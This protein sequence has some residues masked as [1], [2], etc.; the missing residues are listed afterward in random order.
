MKHLIFGRQGE[1]LAFEYL[2]KH[3]V[4]IITKNYKNKLG[5]IDL[6]GKDK[7]QIV[8]FEVKRSKNKRFG[9][10]E[11]RVNYQ[12]I[13]KIIKVGQEFLVRNNLI[14]QSWRIDVISIQNMK[15]KWI[16]NVTN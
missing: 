15:I 1:K 4:A 13:E 9:F 2:K 12:K 16:K 6:I 8:F 11:E 3:G 7:E 10:P 5:E 14:D